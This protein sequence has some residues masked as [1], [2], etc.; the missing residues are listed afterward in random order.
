MNDTTKE[1]ANEIISIMEQEGNQQVSDAVQKRVEVL[2]NEIATTD[3]S[4]V[5]TRDTLY[6]VMLNFAAFKASDKI[7]EALAKLNK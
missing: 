3:S 1:V 5:R 4:W 7:H 2:T 6:I